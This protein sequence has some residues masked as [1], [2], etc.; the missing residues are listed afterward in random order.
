MRG[1]R[2]RRCVGGGKQGN[3]K[4]LDMFRPGLGGL[5]ISW[6]DSKSYR[7]LAL[8]TEK[9]TMTM[10]DDGLPEV[11][12]ATGMT[13]DKIQDGDRPSFWN[14]FLRMRTAFY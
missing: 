3:L 12:L 5:H 1:A 4:H 7:S 10:T 11:V 13:L 14:T 6:A 9:P 2:Q 8:K